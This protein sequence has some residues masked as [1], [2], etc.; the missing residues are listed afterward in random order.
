LQTLEDDPK[1][2]DIPVIVFSAKELTE[3]EQRTLAP[4]ISNLIEKG[5]FDRNQFLYI[6]KDILK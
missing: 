6:V 2:R 4:R 3:E 1:L 5:A